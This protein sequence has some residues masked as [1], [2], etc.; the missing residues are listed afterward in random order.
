MYYEINIARN[1]LHLFATSDRSLTTE[2][3]ARKLFAELKA[4]FPGD[5]V[6]VSCHKHSGMELNWDVV[7]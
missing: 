5:S 3:E 1:G 2:A 7:S 6:T 4:K